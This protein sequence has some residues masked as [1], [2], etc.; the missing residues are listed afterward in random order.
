MDPHDKIEKLGSKPLMNILDPIM[1]KS[2]TL[3]L[4]VNQSFIELL[5]FIQMEYGLNALFEF[6]ILDDDKNS[7]F[8]NIEVNLFE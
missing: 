4:E 1:Y 5:T 8:N 3:H 6:D 2:P 7:S